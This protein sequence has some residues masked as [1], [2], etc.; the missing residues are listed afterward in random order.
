M[1]NTKVAGLCVVRDARD[2]I[3]FI[4]GHYLRMG[5][6]HLSF[7]DDGSSDGTFEFLSAMSRLTRRI[8]V[9][10]VIRENF[11][12]PELINETVDLLIQAGYRTI[13]PFDADEFWDVRALELEHRYVADSEIAFFGRWVNFVQQSDATFPRPFGL[14]RIRYHAPARNEANSASVMSLREPFVCHS[15]CKIAFKAPRQLEFDRGQHSLS[16]ELPMDSHVFEIFHLPL[17]YRSEIEK[18]GINY[19]PRRA[20]TRQDPLFSWQSAFHR[21]VVITGRVDEVWAA[22]A[23][24]NLAI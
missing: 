21:Q 7:V 8:S 12:Q 6:G 4:C 20:N 15:D 5:F 10:R 18:R 19:E 17:R 1:S 16:D 22:N 13:V 14:F 2:I 9:R 3:P 23:P 11:D 24:M